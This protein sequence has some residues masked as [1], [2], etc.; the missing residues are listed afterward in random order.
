MEQVRTPNN[1]SRMKTINLKILM[2]VI[3]FWFFLLPL[4]LAQILGM[5]IPLSEE[6]NGEDNE[7]SG[8][9]DED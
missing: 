9:A 6:V 3:V 7:E 1:I 8:N 5:F 2:W 4:G